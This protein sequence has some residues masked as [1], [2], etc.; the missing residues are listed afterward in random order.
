MENE[1]QRLGQETPGLIRLNGKAVTDRIKMASRPYADPK[2]Q[3]DRP[4]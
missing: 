3:R 2:H 4:F 1:L